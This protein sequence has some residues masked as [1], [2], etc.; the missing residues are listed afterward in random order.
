[1]SGMCWQG[2]LHGCLCWHEWWASLH[3]GDDSAIVV[4]ALLDLATPSSS[5]SVAILVLSNHGGCSL[6][7]L[8]EG[9]G[10]VPL[11]LAL[12]LLEGEWIGSLQGCQR[13][14]LGIALAVAAALVA[15]Q[16]L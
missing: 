5:S 11:G 12:L 9:Q 8:S 16:P 1:M 7:G 14:S 3:I 6:A 15:A 4:I 13:A 2:C 10:C